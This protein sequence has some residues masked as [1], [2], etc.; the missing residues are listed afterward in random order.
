[1]VHCGLGGL[2]E[3]DEADQCGFK[4]KSILFIHVNAHRGNVS[5]NMVE[6]EAKEQKSWDRMNREKSKD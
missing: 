1:M 4:F 5:K 3:R 6:R 2:R